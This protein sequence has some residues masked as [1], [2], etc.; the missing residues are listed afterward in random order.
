MKIPI[1]GEGIVKDLICYCFEYSVDD[2][3]QNYLENGKS[4]I[5]EKIQM[6]KKFGNCQCATKNPKGKWCLGDVRQVVDELKG[7]SSF[8]VINWNVDGLKVFGMRNDNQSTNIIKLENSLETLKER[9]N[10]DR[11]KIRFLALLSPTC[12]LWRDKGARAVHE[13][14]FKKYPDADVSASIVWIPILEKDTFAAAIPSVKF[15]SDKRIQHFY[16]NSRMVGKNI[17]DS[18]GWTGNVAWDIY[19]FYRPFV[20]WVETP[21][22]P[23]FWMH[24][25]TDGWATKEKYRTGGDLKNELSISM[26]KL[27]KWML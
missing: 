27:V 9:F 8:G 20:E 19:L 15:L 26:G 13:N 25:L 16:D 17:A 11:E 7:K 3:N 10:S 5:M 21:P 14:V 2:I 24:Q 18:V 1:E 6:E 12:P 23:I 22:K 4:T